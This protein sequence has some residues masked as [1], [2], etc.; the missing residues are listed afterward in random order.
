M[1]DPD[2]SDTPDPSPATVRNTA[3]GLLA[4]REHSRLE[5]TR[6]LLQRYAGADVL[7]AEVITDLAERGLQSDLRC[8]EAFIHSRTNRG[9]GPL[10]IRS[11]LRQRGLEGEAVDALLEAAASNQEEATSP[12]DAEPSWED[13]ARS[14]AIRRFGS[15][16]P[17]DRRDWARRAR[18]LSSRGFPESVVMQVL[19]PIP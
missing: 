3:L 14:Q 18:F 12:S 16:P 19:G 8:A 4:R 6:K 5:L 15:E 13:R 11:E 2:T 17:E 1:T 9:Q 7:I 10:R